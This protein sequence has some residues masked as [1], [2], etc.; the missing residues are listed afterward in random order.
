MAALRP[1]MLVCSIV[2]LVSALP[3]PFAFTTALAQQ[4]EANEEIEFN[5]TIKLVY[6]TP[7]NPALRSPKNAPIVNSNS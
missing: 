6:E 2:L 4:A 5:G 7:K 1:G 3:L